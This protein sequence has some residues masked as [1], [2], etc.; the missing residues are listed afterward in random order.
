MGCEGYIDVAPVVSG[1]HLLG[2]EEDQERHPALFKVTEPVSIW[3][4]HSELFGPKWCNLATYQEGLNKALKFSPED[5]E[6]VFWSMQDYGFSGAVCW[7][8][9]VV[10]PESQLDRILTVH[11]QDL[12][13][14]TPGGHHD[15][16]PHEEAWAK[17]TPGY[18]IV[19]NYCES[20]SGWSGAPQTKPK[21][22]K[23]GEC[24]KW[25]LWT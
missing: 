6:V 14:I 9:I 7:R 1:H 13:E 5:F 20:G 15:R 24:V 23:L 22:V 16:T 12:R 17:I 3:P 11:D 25:E 21:D 18:W 8:G 10:V 4:L 19:D 2:I